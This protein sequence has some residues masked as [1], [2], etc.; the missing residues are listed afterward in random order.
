M[1]SEEL[2]AT[3]LNIL[4]TKSHGTQWL[5]WE[6]ESI[7]AECLEEFGEDFP[8]ENIE[9]INAIASVLTSR[10]YYDYWEIFENVNNALS[11]ENVDFTI[12][13]PNEPEHMV[14]AM[15]EAKFNDDDDESF[16]FDVKDYICTV[17]KKNGFIKCPKIL[18]N[19]FGIKYNIPGSYDG[20]TMKEETRKH[21]RIVSHALIKIEELKHHSE[22]LFNTNLSDDFF[23]EFDKNLFL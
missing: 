3:I 21:M 14:W 23:R 6:P 17:L 22:K 18:E 11:G 1:I 9:K 13:T 19:F 16:S 15:M 7:R 5:N 12:I 4:M 2:P 20:E 10:Q 8:D